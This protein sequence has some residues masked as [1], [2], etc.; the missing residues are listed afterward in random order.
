MP[1]S[2]RPS[3]SNR[4]NSEPPASANLKFLYYTVASSLIAWVLAASGLF[5]QL[6]LQYRQ[7]VAWLSFGL[8][9]WALVSF[10]L[11]IVN[12]WGAATGRDLPDTKLSE[13]LVG[14]VPA[15][16]V[17]ILNLGVAHRAFLLG[18]VS[19]L[20]ERVAWV[21]AA[22]FAGC[23]LFLLV[24]LLGGWSSWK[25]VISS[26]TPKLLISSITLP[27]ILYEAPERHNPQI[28][29]KVSYR[30][31]PFSSSNAVTL[32]VKLRLDPDILTWPRDEISI[33]VPDPARPFD[34]EVAIDAP[35]ETTLEKLFG[36]LTHQDLPWDH[37][38]TVQCSLKIVVST[39]IPRSG[40]FSREHILS[41]E[42]E[43][44][45]P[46]Q[47]VDRHDV[48]RLLCYGYIK[49][50]P[51]S[52]QCNPVLTASIDPS[53]GTNVC[54]LA[55]RL[56]A[57]MNESS[58]AAVATVLVHALVR[59]FFHSTYER[60]EGDLSTVEFDYLKQAPSDR[61]SVEERLARIPNAPCLFEH[62]A[63]ELNNV[64]KRYRRLPPSATRRV[65][66]PGRTCVVVGGQQTPRSDP[67]P[68]DNTYVVLYTVLGFEHSPRCV[69]LFRFSTDSARGVYDML[70]EDCVEHLFVST[71]AEHFPELATT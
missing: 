38:G 33:V 65:V 61:E 19:T 16:V 29:L 21:G 54:F 6:G 30:P 18:A 20:S 50:I 52:L 1:R 8:T 4:H 2:S 57:H 58:S 14:I 44:P 46:Y 10:A 62:I 36:T 63:A 24:G 9:F 51:N 15:I 55:R 12:I 71:I 45:L 25:Q 67:M 31:G 43:S 40:L 48:F 60:F 42:H 68:R 66:S 35:R 28:K 26:E 34:E 53:L 56:H 47:L 32:S 5:E 37:N 41:S 7:E 13:F 69:S 49:S 70:S 39:V 17:L 27:S 59:M 64:L 22:S 3:N 23:V 11:L